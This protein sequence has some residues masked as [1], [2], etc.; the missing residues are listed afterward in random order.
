MNIN[1]KLIV[2]NIDVTP[3]LEELYVY[4]KRHDWSDLRSKSI[5]YHKKTKHISLRDHALHKKNN[6]VE[7]YRNSAKIITNRYSAPYFIKTFS[8]L[9]TFEEKLEGQLERVMIVELQGN[10]NVAPHIDVG[11]Y[12]TQRDRYHLVLKRGHSINYCDDEMQVYS[13]GELWWFDNKKTIQLKIK[14]TSQE[15]ILFSI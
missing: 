1:F 7:Y 12:Y 4:L 2:K 13:T 11:S 3:I 8:L 9:K 15:F 5:S 14:V 10:S 6:T